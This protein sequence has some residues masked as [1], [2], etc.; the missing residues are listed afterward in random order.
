MFVEIYINDSFTF[1]VS[2]FDIFLSWIL[3]DGNDILFRQLF[4]KT[5]DSFCSSCVIAFICSVWMRG[6]L[7]VI[8]WRFDSVWCF[9]FFLGGRC[10]YLASVSVL[11]SS[12]DVS[13]PIYWCICRDKSPMLAGSSFYLVDSFKLAGGNGFQDSLL[14]LPKRASTDTQITSLSLSGLKRCETTFVQTSQNNSYFWPFRFYGSPG[15]P[16][17][18]E[19]DSC[20]TVGTRQASYKSHQEERPCFFPNS[21]LHSKYVRILIWVSGKSFLSLQ[22][23]PWSHDR[24]GDSQALVL[25]DQYFFAKAIIGVLLR[26]SS[27]GG[28]LD[29][30]LSSSSSW[31][32]ALLSDVSL[33][34]SSTRSLKCLAAFWWAFHLL[35]WDAHVFSQ[36]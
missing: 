12:W 9:Y 30:A 26:S 8:T 1:S 15:C 22:P 4:S 25:F 19:R 11:Q 7:I 29:S 23:N 3:R 21:T 32:S 24:I 14:R 16:N 35:P 18:H 20:L 33:K 17:L 28:S 2:T 5:I 10:L 6:V 27:L 31:P 13:L 34:S 36:W